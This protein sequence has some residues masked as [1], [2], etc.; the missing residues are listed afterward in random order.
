VRG[1]CFV[2][3]EYSR[4][5]RQHCNQVL[6]D[7]LLMCLF[8]IVFLF[9]TAV[10]LVNRDTSG[11]FNWLTND[12]RVGTY[13]QS[14]SIP[15]IGGQNHYIQDTGGNHLFYCA[16]C[17]DYWG[18]VTGP[19]W[20][21]L[22]DGTF[23]G[24]Y[25]AYVATPS[26]CFH[27]AWLVKS[28]GASTWNCAGSQW[29]T[30]EVLDINLPVISGPGSAASSST[31]SAAPAPTPAPAPAPGTT[32]QSLPICNTDYACKD[33]STSVTGSVCTNAGCTTSVACC[34]SGQLSCTNWGTPSTCTCP[35]TQQC[36]VTYTW[37]ASSSWGQC[38][39]PC[40]GPGMGTQSRSVSC[41]CS[42]GSSVTDSYCDSAAKPP[43]AQQCATAVCPSVVSSSTGGSAAGA[44]AGGNAGGGTTQPNHDTSSGK[45]PLSTSAIV[46]I[47]LGIV[48]SL[49]L[50]TAIIA[51]WFRRHR[52]AKRQLE[53]LKDKNKS[54][55]MAPA[56]ATPTGQN[57]AA[58]EQ[59]E[60]E[61]RI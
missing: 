55:E 49:A 24:A 35:T 13:L 61:N 58:A 20:I 46:G 42:D 27:N 53:L 60:G 3:I 51:V 1:I 29:P 23:K 18:A 14:T 40:G 12:Q 30:C 34:T 41:E 4:P 19:V 54:S 56:G 11:N 47:V 38:V 52:N 48:L 45:P 36:P 16:C 44:A 33:A 5:R 26:T 43:T 9:L 25:A 28:P 15:T 6:S 59:P 32:Y 37:S 21:V 22:D 57:A 2:R 31:G 7:S 10:T 17:T 50:F 39:G 8:G